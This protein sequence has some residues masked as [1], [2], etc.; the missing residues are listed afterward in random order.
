MNTKIHYIF[1]FK[2]TL[3]S[4]YETK[5]KIVTISPRFFKIFLQNSNSSKLKRLSI[6][7]IQ[8]NS[9]STPNSKTFRI[10]IYN[11]YN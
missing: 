9:K 4:L 7:N 2:N 11:T 6:K 1:K 3:E 8:K 10:T 5:I